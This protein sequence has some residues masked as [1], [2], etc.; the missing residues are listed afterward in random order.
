VIR[1]L[2]EIILQFHHCSLTDF[3]NSDN[4]FFSKDTTLGRTVPFSTLQQLKPT[5]LPSLASEN[6]YHSTRHNPSYPHTAE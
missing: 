5:K 3:K 4:F 2:E 1:C 6:V